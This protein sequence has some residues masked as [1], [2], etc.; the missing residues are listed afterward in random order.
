M[1]RVLVI[2]DNAAFRESVGLC[3]EARGFAVE[4]ARNAEEGLRAACGGTPGLILL[5]VKLPDG[6]GLSVLRELQRREVPA[7]VVVMTGFPSSDTAIDAL[8]MGA[9]DYLSKP[10]PSESLIELARRLCRRPNA[11]AQASCGEAGAPEDDLLVGQSPGMVEV[12]KAV[13]RAAPTGVPV[14]LRG[15]SGTGKEPV[16]RAIH[17]H[18]G[19]S[20]PFVAVN[21]S[22]VVE[23]LAESELFG[24]ERGAFTGAVERRR[25]RFELAAGGTLFL[26]EIGDAPASVQ[27]KLL[28][29]LDR[30]EFERVGGRETL[31]AQARIVAATNRDLEEMVREGGFRA[32][33]YYRLSVVT[34]SL[35]ALRERPEDIPPLVRHL[36]RRVAPRVGRRAEGVS[37]SALLRLVEYPWPGNVREL[38]NVLTRAVIRAG[39]GVV[40]DDDLPPLVA[41]EGRPGEEDLRPRTLAEVERIHI[42]RMLRVAQGNRGRACDLLGITRPTL[43]RKMREYGL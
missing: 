24:H 2:D 18:S 34:I 33:L 40:G 1:Q 14:L 15:E 43:R 3:L 19:R 23:T 36:L 26:D 8:R 29:A 12:F 17:R 39:G 13:G 25:G 42:E 5:D 11:R 28:R 41:P 6:S 16:A 10:I 31:H 7:P 30:G 27:A 9:T 37:R 32:D 20:G 21:C 38:E 22:A 4:A 35:P